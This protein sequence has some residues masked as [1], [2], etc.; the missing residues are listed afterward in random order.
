[1]KAADRQAVVDRFQGGELD[2]LVLH[3]AVGKYGHTL[4]QARA[5]VYMQR[6][7]HFDDW[8]QSLYRVRRIGTKRSP[9]ICVLRAH[10][11]VDDLVVHNL[12]TK[13]KAAWELKGSDLAERLREQTFAE[14]PEQFPV[15]ALSF[16]E[17]G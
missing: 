17:R 9:L 2:A 16:K 15:E 7:F 4:T 1:V 6:N 14:E 13:G 5:A 12:N 3:P 10:G 11:T 8:L